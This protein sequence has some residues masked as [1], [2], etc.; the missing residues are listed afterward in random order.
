MDPLKSV[1]L[2][3]WLPPTLPKIADVLYGQPRMKRWYS[4]W[5]VSAV[6][7][8]YDKEAESTYMKQWDSDSVNIN[9]IQF[10]LISVKYEAPNSAAIANMYSAYKV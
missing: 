3:F 7:E 8:L 5:A 9:R 10:K 6:K 4:I 2:Q 1:I